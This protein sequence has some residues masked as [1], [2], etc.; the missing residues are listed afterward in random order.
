MKG[1]Y[2]DR[3]VKDP[4]TGLIIGVVREKGGV[5]S[6]GHRGELSTVWSQ[7]VKGFTSDCIKLHSQPGVD[8]S[9]EDH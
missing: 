5:G 3:Y 9:G 6:P 7:P 4:K 8:Y 2:E 1:T